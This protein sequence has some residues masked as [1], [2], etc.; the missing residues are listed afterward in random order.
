MAGQELLDTWK[1][2]FYNCFLDFQIVIQLDVTEMFQADRLSFYFWLSQAHRTMRQLPRNI[3]LY[4]FKF[5]LVAPGISMQTY[6]Q[7]IFE[8][9]FGILNHTVE[10]IF[11]SF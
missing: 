7:S 8:L 1:M 6:I 9:S 4:F 11:T 10:F 3:Q 5:I 2:T